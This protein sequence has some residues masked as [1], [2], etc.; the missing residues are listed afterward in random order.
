LG[1]PLLAGPGTISTAMNFV[2]QGNSFLNTIIIILVFA[3]VCVITYLM[4]I[5]SE[6]IANKLRPTLIKA[7]SKIMGLILAVIAIQMLINGIFNV[8]HEYPY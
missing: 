4:F 3:V 5:L 7:I 2:G 6:N 8:I 1:I